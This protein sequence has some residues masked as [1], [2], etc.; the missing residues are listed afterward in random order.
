MAKP[1]TKVVRKDN[2]AEAKKA[3]KEA[4][5]ERNKHKGSL[6]AKSRRDYKSLSPKLKKKH[7]ERVVW[8]K[9]KAHGATD[10]EAD[11]AVLIYKKRRTHRN[12]GKHAAEQRR[13]ATGLQKQVRG[14]I[15]QK[16][17]T[18]RSGHS[19]ALKKISAAKVPA[20]TK[21][22]MR[23]AEKMRY[24]KERG[25]LAKERNKAVNAHK[26]RLTK[27]KTLAQKHGPIKLSNLISN[28]S[29]RTL[30]QKG[31][32][33]Q[34]VKPGA[35]TKAGGATK[36]TPR[37]SAESPSAIAD[38]HFATPAKRGRKPGTKNAAKAAPAAA[39]AAEAKPKRKYTKKT[40]AAAAPAAPAV[41]KRK[42]G[43]PKKVAA[44]PAAAPAAEK[45]KPGRPKKAEAAPAVEAKPK[46][47]YTKKTPA[48]AAPATPPKVKPA[49]AKKPAAKK[50]DGLVKL[51]K[52]G[53]PAQKRGPKPKTTATPTAPAPKPKATTAKGEAKPKPKAAAKNPTKKVEAA[54]KPAAKPS[55]KP[56]R[57]EAKPKPK[58]KANPTTKVA[59]KDAPQKGGAKAKT[60]AAVPQKKGNPRAN[61]K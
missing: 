54:A 21:T 55:A 33:L 5:M 30:G 24:A 11:K 14:Q 46:R 3:R 19:A 57:G 32:R 43:R 9:A 41:E 18:I 10:A 16:A 42:P 36:K 44:A 6:N 4:R 49:K 61:L 45:R 39:P 27:I 34:T 58:G 20:A 13:Q 2:S 37:K 38:K 35:K 59:A 56:A 48:A 23:N 28:Y 29:K 47:K 51:N 8:R 26:S 1:V 17:A 31:K 53:S 25:Q 15:K 22:K 40:P 52:N 60:G 7:L 12:A 50:D